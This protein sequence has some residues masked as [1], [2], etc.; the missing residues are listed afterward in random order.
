MM[1]YIVGTTDLGYSLPYFTLCIR[2]LASGPKTHPGQ[3]FMV[4][5]YTL[6]KTQVLKTGIPCSA[7]L[8]RVRQN[9]GVPPFLGLIKKK[10]LLG[11]IFC[12]KRVWMG[13]TDN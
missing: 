6:F 5:S 4:K 8:T 12:Y 1:I 2:L 10:M 3:T 9:K 11:L 7:T 13:L